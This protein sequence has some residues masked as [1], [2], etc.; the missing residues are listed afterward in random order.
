MNLNWTEVT[1]SLTKCLLGLMLALV[2]LT[3]SSAQA[4]LDEKSKV[5]AEWLVNFTIEI[6]SRSHHGS[7]TCR[8]PKHFSVAGRLSYCSCRTSRL[9]THH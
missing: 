2:S 4:G 1:R 3:P 8:G 6:S 7:P 9:D 5:L